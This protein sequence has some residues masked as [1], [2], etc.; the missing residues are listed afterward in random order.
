MSCLT[1][2]MP[3]IALLNIKWVQ[4]IIEFVSF[5]M[6]NNGQVNDKEGRMPVTVVF[7]STLYYI[8]FDEKKKYINYCQK[9]HPSNKILIIYKIWS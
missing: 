3:V 8:D 9:R 5:I 1:V 7:F 2:S 4:L 6:L